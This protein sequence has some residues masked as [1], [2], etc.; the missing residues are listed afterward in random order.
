MTRPRV[1]RGCRA[2]ILDLPVISE[3]LEQAWSTTCAFLT[4][5]TRGA[6]SAGFANE[7]R[8]ERTAGAE[9]AVGREGGYGARAELGLSARRRRH[10][11]CTT[12]EA[13][14]RAAD[15]RRRRQWQT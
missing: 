7:I 13:A 1:G 9:D 8:K 3:V 15:G 6:S 4:S 2:W 12:N 11:V 14:K 5:D 10:A